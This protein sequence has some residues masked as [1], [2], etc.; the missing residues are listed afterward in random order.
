[1]IVYFKIYRIKGCFLE[2]YKNLDTARLE[3]T[4]LGN[5]YTNLANEAI[6]SLEMLI[7]TLL[8]NYFLFEVTL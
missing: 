6:C 1:M 3:P 7:G 2:T 4:L 8:V 5:Q